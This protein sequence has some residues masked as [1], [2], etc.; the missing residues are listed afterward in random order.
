MM[1]PKCAQDTYVVSTVKGTVNERYRKCKNK[2]CEYSFMTVE[3]IR[4]DDYWREYAKE[5]AEM[6]PKD[7][8]KEEK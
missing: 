6:N 1:C 8:K 4:F 5:S 3:A 7:F 2:H